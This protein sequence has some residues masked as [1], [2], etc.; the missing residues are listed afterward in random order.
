MRLGVCYYPEHWD[1]NI[2]REDAKRMIDLGL[3]VVRIGEFSWAKI[4]PAPGVYEW[5]WLDEA[6]DVLGCA[7]LKLILGTPTATPPKWLVDTHPDILAH[8]R[9]GR[10]R[11]FGSR[12]HYCFSSDQYAAESR[13]IVTAMVERYGQNNAV[14]AWQTDN[15]YGCH[16]TVRSYS[17]EAA[18]AFRKWLQFRYGDIAALNEAWGTIFWSQVY[19]S[20]DE[21]DLPNLTVTEPNPSHVFDFYRFSSDQVVAYNKMQV[22][23]IRANSPGREI[24]HNFMGHFTDFDHFRLSEDI[25]IAGWDSYPLGFLDVEDYPAAEKEKFMRQGHPDFAGFH[26]DLYRGCADGRLAVMEQQPGPVNWA[27]HNP[28]PLP[29]MVRLWTHEAAAHGAELLCYFRWRQAPFAQEH[30]H[31]GLLRPDNSP[32]QAY[33]EVQRAAKEFVD[34]KTQNE[35]ASFKSYAPK[36]A[37]IFSYETQ[38]MS[39]VAPQ[40]AQ[41]NYIRIVMQWYSVA[42]SLGCDIDIVAPGSELDK[43]EFVLVPSLFHVSASALEAFSK[44]RATIFFGPRSGSKTET[45]QIPKNLAPG[46]LQEI[47]PLRVTHSESFPDFHTE[48]GKFVGEKVFSHIWLDHVETSLAPLVKSETGAGLLYRSDRIWMFTTVPDENFL[49]LALTAAQENSVG[50]IKSLPTGLRMRANGELQYAFNYN[51]EISDLPSQ[52]FPDIPTTLIGAKTIFPADVACWR[53]Q[54]N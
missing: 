31:A 21:V 15:E 44:T 16:D 49:Y 35:S 50:N 11:Q 17:P 52:F 14:E 18:K 23:I 2:W 34:L 33:E 46:P 38:W 27:R 40:G 53:K 24:Y 30:M 9:E 6:V 12:R 48:H 54:Q 41:W 4:E 42:R 32:A 29:G 37:L 22:D 47:F 36:V 10:P 43:Y 13:R 7:G 45:I 19:R 39:E 5:N 25:D 26:H 51:A 3:E 28:A 20:F 1:R 8:D